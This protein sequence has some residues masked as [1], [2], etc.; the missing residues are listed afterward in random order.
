[1]RIH[2]VNVLNRVVY[3]EDVDLIQGTAKEDK[4]NLTL[5]SEWDGLEIKVCFSDGYNNNIMPEK[6]TN[7]NY[8]VPWEVMQKPGKV[9]ISVIGIDEKTEQILK[10]AIGDKFIVHES[11]VSDISEITQRTPE[12]LKAMRGFSAYDIAVQHGYSGTEE[13]WLASLKGDKGDKG[14]RGFSAYE[15]AQQAGFPG[16]EAAWRASL[17]GDKGDQGIQGIQGISAYEVAKKN[18]FNGTEVEWLASLKGDKGD[19]GDKGNTGEKGDTGDSAY[20]LAINNGF[21]GTEQQWLSSLKGDKGD[22]G[23]TG[24]KGDQGIQGI[25][26]IQGVKGDSAYTVAVNNGF[27]GSETDWLASLKTGIGWAKGWTTGSNGTNVVLPVNR[28][29]ISDMIVVYY[30]TNDTTNTPFAYTYLPMP[31]FAN[32]SSEGNNIPASMLNP[33]AETKNLNITTSIVT[34]GIQV[35]V[36]DGSY[37]AVGDTHYTV[38]MNTYYKLMND[39]SGK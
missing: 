11:S 35:T 18:G 8:V 5:D 28:T 29:D 4:V 36:A 24:A 12:T 21:K 7:G 19:K 25:Q 3:I 1:M 31:V 9:V 30:M 38:T 14:D 26:G 6:D 22:K 15:L 2:N 32:V 13:Q 10:H 27:K 39:G 17:K 33:D 16:D 34:D 20:A 23:D 37:V